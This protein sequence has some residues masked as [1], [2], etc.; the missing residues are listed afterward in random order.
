MGAVAVPWS[1]RD[2]PPAELAGGTLASAA[3]LGV[4]RPVTG[5]QP[6]VAGTGYVLDVAVHGMWLRYRRDQ[7]ARGRAVIAPLPWSSG[8]R[9][10]PPA[11]GPSYLFT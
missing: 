7:R 4:P 8:S 5:S 9:G 2:Q 6:M 11:A 1:I 10:I 3:A